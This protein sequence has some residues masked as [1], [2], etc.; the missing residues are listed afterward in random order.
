MD[1]HNKLIK[2]L[3]IIAIVVATIGGDILFLSQGIAE[4]MY[5]NLEEQSTVTNN[6]NVTFDT[7]FK[8]GEEK[9]HSKKANISAGETLVINIAVNNSRSIISRSLKIRKQ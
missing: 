2:T 4:A 7:Y 1:I 3:M 8:E 5:E 9:V 6:S